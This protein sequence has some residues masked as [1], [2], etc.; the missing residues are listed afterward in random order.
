MSLD[1]R[2]GNHL[3]S[4]FHDYLASQR[5][6]SP[7]TIMS[8]RDSIKLFFCFA[9][10]QLKKPI[11]DLIIDEL[12]ADVVLAFLDHLEEKRGNSIPT[13]NSRLAALRVFFRHVATRDPQSFGL[14]QRILG[15]PAKRAPKPLVDYLEREE[16]EA[17][18]NSINHSSPEGRRDYALLSFA[19]Q[20]GA[21]VQEIVNVRACDIQ[22]ELPARVRIW[23]KGRKERL[24]P[25]WNRTAD[26]LRTWFEERN[27]DPR[28]AMPVFINMRGRPLTRWGVR[29]ILQKYVRLA[30]IGGSMVASKRVHPHMLRHTAAVHMLHAGAEPNAIRDILGH[31]SAET[32]WRY[33]RI[34]ME[35]KRKAIES[36]SPQSSPGDSPV[37][38]WRR[39]Q[40]LLA[41]LEALGRRR[42]YVEPHKL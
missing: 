27:V 30:A 2:L 32:T 9:G 8:Y 23:G 14:C 33:A 13:R 25:L 21:R 20:T 39:D 6:V 31:A 36:C 4:F 24:L 34:S 16:L 40:D 12:T 28:S 18:I 15:I 37:P 42:D 26:L 19:Y 41:Q 10:T 29:Y 5:G 17:I 11:A 35:M 22:L 3:H 38:I 7:H 1:N